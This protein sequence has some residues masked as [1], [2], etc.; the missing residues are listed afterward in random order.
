VS[1]LRSEIKQIGPFSSLAEEAF[2]NLRR[3]A[4]HL[5]AAEASLLAR[6]GLTPAQYN[7]LRILRGAGPEG[8]PCQEV[9]ARLIARVPDVTRLIDRLE[10]A[11]LVLRARC[12]ED[13]R[14]VYVRIQRPALDLLKRIDEPLRQWAQR[15]FP[16]LSP[17]ELATLNG[18]LERARSGA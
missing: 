14:V 7:V 12:T 10:T 5:A 11:G 18:L 17:K 8:H 15:L 13:R 2:L 3:T 1:K 9:G 6:F 16:A 4:E